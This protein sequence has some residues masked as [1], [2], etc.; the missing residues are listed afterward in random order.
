[1]AQMFDS[2]AA[3]KRFRRHVATRYA[4]QNKRR[5]L[6][7]STAHYVRLLRGSLEPSKLVSVERRWAY[8]EKVCSA[9]AGSRT[10]ALTEARALL[11]CDV[12]K[13]EQR[14][15]ALLPAKRFAAAVDE[16]RNSARLFR[17]RMLLGGG[18]R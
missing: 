5:V 18:V 17:S 14:A 12:P 11:R 9:T 4:N 2:T 16:L 7:R 10:I 3:A 13:I 8:L 15:K 1:V 6:T